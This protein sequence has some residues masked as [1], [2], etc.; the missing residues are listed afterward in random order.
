MRFNCFAIGL[1]DFYRK[2]Y[3]DQVQFIGTVHFRLRLLL[4]C[5]QGLLPDL[6]YFLIL[7]K[8]AAPDFFS[9]LECMLQAVA[10]ENTNV[11]YS[12]GTFILYAF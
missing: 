9:H 11:Y 1:R 12:N 4:F 5:L 8:H 6:D 2:Y 3:D 10:I 7:S